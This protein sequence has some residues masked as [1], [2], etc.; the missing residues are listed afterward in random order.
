MFVEG[1]KICFDIVFSNS[2]IVVEV[3]GSYYYSRDVFG[4]FCEFG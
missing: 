4:C 2:R 1:G 3:D